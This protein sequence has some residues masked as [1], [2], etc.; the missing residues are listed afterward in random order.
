MSKKYFADFCDDPY[1]VFC[2]DDDADAAFWDEFFYTE[3]KSDEKESGKK[4]TVKILD[5]ETGEEQVYKN[6]K[7]NPR[8]L[9]N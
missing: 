2:Q 3:E 8:K 4:Y 7:V 9:P 6:I 1:C 5:E